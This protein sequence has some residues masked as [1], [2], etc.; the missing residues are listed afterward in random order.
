MIAICRRICSP[1][2]VNSVCNKD[3][4]HYYYNIGGLH[5]KIQNKLYYKTFRKCTLI[6]SKLVVSLR[7]H[8]VKKNSF[9]KKF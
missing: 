3:Q 1:E 7:T 6:D 2:G 4:N 8:I 9:I 5:Y